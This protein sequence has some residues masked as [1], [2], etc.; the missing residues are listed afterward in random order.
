MSKRFVLKTMGCKANQ[1]ESG[2]I[3]EKL[4][5]Q[6][7]EQVNKAKDAEFFIL[8]SCTVTHKSDNEALYLLRNAKHENPDII[9]IITGCVAQVRKNELLELDDVDMVLGNN[10]KLDITQYLDINP[11]CIV[12][13]LMEKENFTPAVLNDITKT[14]IGLKIQDG[15]NSRCAYCIIPF[16]R[17]K[18]RSAKIDFLV[19]QIN[20]YAANGYKEVVLT[21]IHIGQWGR[22]WGL[23]LIDLLKEIEKTDI[24]RYRLGSLNPSE[25]LSLEFI[26]IPPWI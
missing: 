8:N 5:N 12:E 18:S 14:R 26:T 9:N 4:L 7:F 24:K 17:G 1:F 23:S 11:T 19:Q 2:I 10:E 22:E 6:G 3:I 15:C 25:I 13:D 21:G 16:A 20:K